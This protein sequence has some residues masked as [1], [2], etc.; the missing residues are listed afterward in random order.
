MTLKELLEKRRAYQA[1]LPVEVTEE[2][3]YDLASAAQLSA[4]CYNSQPWRFVFVYGKENL[5]RIFPALS[6][7]N[8]WAKDSSLIVAVFSKPDDD[9]IVKGKEYYLFDTGMA[10]AN[11][12]LQATEIG[13][14]AHPMAGYDE[15]LAKEILKIPEEFILITLIG[16]GKH[17]KNF[18]E[19]LS[20]WQLKSEKERPPRKSLSEFV[21][22]NEYKYKN[23]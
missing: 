9:C 1:L 21:F 6:K 3:I 10:V 17:N 15:E 8:A 19:V 14:V 23:G 7:G 13:L 2:M 4:S 18:E 11:L 22:I 5:K 12:I 16:I 20:D